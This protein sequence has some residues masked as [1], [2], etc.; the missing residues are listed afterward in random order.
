MT[1]ILEKDFIPQVG[2]IL[3]ELGYKVILEPSRI[4][5][6]RMWRNDPASLIR[7]PKYRPDILVEHDQ[8]LA[9]VEVKTHPVLLGGV[10]QARQYSDYFE[11]AVVLCVPDDAWANIP[12]S[13]RE[14]ADEQSVRLCPPL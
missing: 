6:R 3:S 1:R 7:G 13:V 9:I 14:F 4:P 5:N 8:K 11:K 10:F 2:E 12:K